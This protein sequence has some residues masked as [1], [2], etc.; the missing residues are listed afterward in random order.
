MQRVDDLLVVA[1]AER[2]DDQRLGLAAGEQ[3]RA[4]GA[5]QDAD[6]GH[7]RADG[8]GVAAVDA[9]A[10][11]HDVAAHDR[12]FQLLQRR[13]EVRVGQLFFAQRRLDRRLR[14]VDRVLALELVADGEGARIASSPAAFTLA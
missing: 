10:V 13:A 5:R 11:R 2:G 14:G 12:A 9:A 4:V 3:R 7:D 8:A 6:F 1:G